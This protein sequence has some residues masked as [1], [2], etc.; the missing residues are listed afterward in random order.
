MNETTKKSKYYK[1]VLDARDHLSEKTKIF[2]AKTT[3]RGKILAAVDATKSIKDYKKLVRRIE[4]QFDDEIRGGTGKL[5]T[6]HTKALRME[7]CNRLIDEYLGPINLALRKPRPSEE[8]QKYA[9][10]MDGK[11]RGWFNSNLTKIQKEF[12]NSD[13]CFIFN[14]LSFYC[15][16]LWDQSIATLELVVNT[17][18][19]H[20]MKNSIGEKRHEL[21]S[22]T[23]KPI[24]L[25]T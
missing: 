2:K 12:R 7:E 6:L 19:P 17:L 18:F 3:L 9:Y 8:L 5:Y 14:D 21:K 20:Y 15:Y 11:F 13:S 24:I 25:N 22:F 4:S 16:D 23:A 10:E 1:L